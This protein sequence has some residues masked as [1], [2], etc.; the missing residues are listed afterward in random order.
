M[1]RCGGGGV[2]EEFGHQAGSA[3]DVCK[4]VAVV[5]VEKDG[6]HVVREEIFLRAR[7][8][9]AEDIRQTV[10]VV[11]EDKSIQVSPTMSRCEST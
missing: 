7:P 1:G 8:V 4:V 10:M 11:E 2:A 6:H 5:V 9:P 3:D